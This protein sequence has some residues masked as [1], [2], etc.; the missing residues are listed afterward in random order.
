MKLSLQSLYLNYAGVWYEDDPR[1]SEG[2]EEEMRG[3][4]CG[5]CVG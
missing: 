2:D 1:V 5:E 4:M 3:W